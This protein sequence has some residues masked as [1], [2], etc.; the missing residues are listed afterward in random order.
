MAIR[1]DPAL[2]VE[3][4]YRF[5]RPG[6]K[7]STLEAGGIGLPILVHIGAQCGEHPGRD[8]TVRM[9]PRPDVSDGQRMIRVAL[10]ERREVEDHQRQDHL[11]E[12]QLVHR[13][14]VRIEMRRRVDMGAVLP[15]H[16]VEERTQMV[17]LD[18]VRPAGRGVG[19]A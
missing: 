11:F 19:S 1:N 9:L 5:Q 7:R 3:E 2:L 14:A 8:P 15:H 16:R 13:D 6:R 12:G 10:E 18:R 4:L 17:L